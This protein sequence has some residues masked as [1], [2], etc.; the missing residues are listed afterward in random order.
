MMQQWHACKKKAKDALLLFRLGDFYEAFYEDAALLAKELNLTL[1]K[2]QGIPM[3]GVPAHA[4]ESYI[5]K[6]VAKG[7]LI[8][9]AEQME[10][11]KQ[12][13]G[14]VKR[15]IVKILSPGTILNAGYLN[16]KANNFFVCLM[17][18]NALYAMALLD[19][20]T[21][22]CRVIEVDQLSTLQDELSRRR[23][24]EILISEKCHKNLSLLLDDLKKQFTFRLNIRDEWHF[25]HRNAYDFLINHFKVHNLD[26][27]GLKGMI[28]AINATG[29]LFAYVQDDL[30]LS[31]DQI[32]KIVPDSLECYMAI[33]RTTERH[34]ELSHSLQNADHS[35]T[36]LNLLDQTLTP[37]GGRLLKTWLTHPLIDKSKIDQRFDAIEELLD[38]RTLSQSLQSHLKSI[39]DLERLITR[40]TTGYTSPRDLIFLSHSLENIS[41]IRSLLNEIQIL[42]L[43]DLLKDLIDPEPVIT[44]IKDAIVEEPPLK[45]IDGGVIKTGY[46]HELDE[47]R[48]LKKS[49]QSFLATYQ[50]K[51]R[52]E[53][54]I[55]TLKVNFNKAFG[56]YIEVSRSQSDKV[57]LSFHRRQTLVNAERFITEELK[58]YEEK[59]LTAE[60]RIVAI[61]QELFSTIRK[62]VANHAQTI[63]NIAKA[64]A[65]LD[66]IQSLTQVAL[67]NN[68]VRPIVDEG[69]E[70]EIIGGRH[71]V[72]ETS[73]IDHTFI[74]ND[75]YL[76]KEFQR[77]I[78]LTGPNMAGK[79]TYI[80]QVAL[81]TILAQI[82]SF[83]PAQSARIGIV[84][85]LFSRIGASDDLTRGQ[86]TFMVEM[87]ETA[88]ILN[89][90]T[91]RSL[92]ILDEIGRG[93]STY[94][95]ISIAWSVAEYL[96]KEKKAK[97]LFATHYWELTD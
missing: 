22:E 86:S 71:P 63:L 69:D 30:H 29:A 47:L 35:H 94:D 61:E 96:L 48:S 27:F 4:C 46:H 67:I 57:P 72:I 9:V 78:L 55:K 2:R 16:D 52:E 42:F 88:N 84:D 25:D 51:L 74:P 97:T 58:T 89:N 32:H 62:K 23:P 43:Q 65:R 87:S 85:K 18:V 8:A 77:L 54:G 41:P 34:L 66:V 73:L 3:S 26:G 33:D 45:L 91:S 90:A 50:T 81:I 83:V 21:G 40:I 31:L 11:P 14:I 75:T 10:D 44:I 5:E 76:G 38:N 95:G 60:D 92:V 70:I 59:I 36:L 20:S 39:R 68:Y 6:M 82:G 24:T 80:R 7:Y 49:G 64:I 37:M 53:T 13:K 93:T 17:Q 79:S 19:L 56:Y 15:D 28:G 12:T 1:T